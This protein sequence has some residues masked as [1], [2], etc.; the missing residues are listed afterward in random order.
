MSRL[1]KV[2]A[3]LLVLVGLL[4]VLGSMNSEKPLVPVEKPVEINA[5]A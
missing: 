5:A 4:F 2:L 3:V 1:V